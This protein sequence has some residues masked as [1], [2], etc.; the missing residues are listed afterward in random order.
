MSTLL[1]S[2]KSHIK[3]CTQFVSV[4]S[5]SIVCIHALHIHTHSRSF[6]EMG[7]YVM[8]RTWLMIKFHRTEGNRC[9]YCWRTSTRIWKQKHCNK[10]QTNS[11]DLLPT[12]WLALLFSSTLYYIHSWGF[13]NLTHVARTALWRITSHSWTVS[14]ST[15]CSL[16][17][18]HIMMHSCRKRNTHTHALIFN[19]ID[20]ITSLFRHTEKLIQ[21]S[22][23]R[24]LTR[25]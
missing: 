20:R 17:H 16:S 22:E 13:R 14:S 25:V 5:K 6:N 1:L 3:V 18:V 9:T 24:A 12:G 11:S 19:R 2:I 7:F 4:M 15:L 23:F 10:N 8:R 21:L